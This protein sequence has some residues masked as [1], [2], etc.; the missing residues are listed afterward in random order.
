MEMVVE[1]Q[2][3]IGE[4]WQLITNEPVDL[5]N[6]WLKLKTAEK[7]LIIS[8]IFIEYTSGLIKENRRM[9][10]CKRLDLQT[11]G[12]TDYAQNP[13]RSLVPNH[14]R[15]MVLGRGGN[16]FNCGNCSNGSQLRYV[17]I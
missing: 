15:L 12:S 14:E 9:S 6:N 10:T 5:R 7:L 17:H 11:Q 4:N 3:M 8:E 16:L 13:P 2:R 1:H